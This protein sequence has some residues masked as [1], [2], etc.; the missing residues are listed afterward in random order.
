METSWFYE[1]LPIQLCI[2]IRRLLQS[3]C[4]GNK[5]SYHTASFQFNHTAIVIQR[6]VSTSNPIKQLTI[7][8][9]L[10]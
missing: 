4:H 10:T 9:K 5:P 7:E 8:I 2:F 1:T 3:I 6:R